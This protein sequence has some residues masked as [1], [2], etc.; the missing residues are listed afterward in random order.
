VS[1]RNVA[2]RHHLAGVCRLGRW[3]VLFEDLSGRR[4]VFFPQGTICLDFA[5]R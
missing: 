2:E 5:A 4:Q 1:F 3:G